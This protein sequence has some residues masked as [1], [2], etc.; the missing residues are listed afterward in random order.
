MSLFC[1]N[2][3][4]SGRVVQFKPNVSKKNIQFTTSGLIL[5]TKTHI[6]T[7]QL[8]SKKI[9]G[10]YTPHAIPVFCIAD[11]WGVHESKNVFSA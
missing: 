8:V 9:I 3:S 7:N 2:G 5:T 10:Y 6:I 4:V 1:G 11:F